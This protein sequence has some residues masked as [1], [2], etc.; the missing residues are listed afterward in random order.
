MSLRDLTRFGIDFPIS[1]GIGNSRDNPIVTHRE[2]PNDYTSIEYGILKCIGTGRGIE[3]ELLQQALLS[4]NG[5]RLEQ[6]KIQTKET[7]AS[8]IITQVENYYFDI[9]E[10]MGS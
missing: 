10:C 9:T 1:G 8:E 2:G 3:W 6:I 5:R 4:Y 7:T